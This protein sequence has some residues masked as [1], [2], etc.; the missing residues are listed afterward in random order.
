MPLA[1]IVLV[2]SVFASIKLQLRI[3]RGLR[4]A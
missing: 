1:L 3:A 2:G 4:P